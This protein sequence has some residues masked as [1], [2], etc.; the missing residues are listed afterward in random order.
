V[1]AALAV[2]LVAAVLLPADAA[3]SSPT[4][5]LTAPFRVR[6][7]PVT[8]GQNPSWTRG[9][10]VLSNE[11][12]EVYW[13]RLD[14]SRRRCLTCGRLRGP[15]GFPQERPQGDWILFCSMGAAREALGGP[16]LGGYGSNLYAMRP[17][18]SRITRLTVATNPPHAPYDNYH[19]FF[20]P[21][22]KH[23]VWTRVRAYPLDQGGERWEMLLGDFVVP[24][25][26]G[27][28]RLSNVRVVGPAFGVYETQPW[29]PDGSGFLFTAFGPRRSPF[30]ASAPGWGNLEL[31]YMRVYGRGVSPGHPRVTH[32]T[33]NAPDYEEQ[34]VFTPDMRGVIVMSNRG[35]RAGWYQTVATAAQATGFDAPDA[36]SIGGP[37]FL[38]DF[39]DRR[40]RTDL[41]LI[42]VR[43]R[44][45]R[46]LTRDRR[47]VPE[48]FWDR[49]YRR[50]L[51]TETLPGGGVQQ[52]RIGRF[53][54]VRPSIRRGPPGR[55]APGLAGRPINRSLLPRL[56]RPGTGPSPPLTSLLAAYARRLFEQLRDLG[57]HAGREIPSPTFSLGES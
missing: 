17:D 31:Y 8:F 14:G 32:L 50:L 19:P 3:A 38:A 49:G 27:R 34:A 25:G 21:D 37:L 57:A 15:N 42:D 22:G 48:F 56:P 5:Y 20:S 1:P 55:P 23:I 44:A 47:V 7:N 33:E 29:A 10:N 6:T 16:C 51:W 2:L 39:S 11:D 28:P 52:T 35:S 24:R 18:G 45:V 43:T 9:G 12:G 41:F 46:R 53:A 4:P 36:G 26:R 40:F 54:G 13:S 30:Q